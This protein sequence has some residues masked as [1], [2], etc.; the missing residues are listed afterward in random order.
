MSN[1]F[2]YSDV[3]HLVEEHSFVKLYAQ[4]DTMLISYALCVPFIIVVSGSCYIY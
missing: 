3:K 2:S 1:L 4:I